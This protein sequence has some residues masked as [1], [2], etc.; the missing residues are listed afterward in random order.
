MPGYFWL[1]FYFGRDGSRHAARAGLELLAL[2]GPPTLA[3]QTAGIPDENTAPP[4]PWDAKPDPRNELGRS[5]RFWG[6]QTVFRAGASASDLGD[7]DG[8]LS[9]RS[10]GL[11]DGDPEPPRTLA[12][13]YEPVDVGGT[14]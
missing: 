12:G 10:P 8:Q 2:S 4:Q 11:S 7:E 5:S 14:G 3:S 9:F 6:S 13:L 1:F